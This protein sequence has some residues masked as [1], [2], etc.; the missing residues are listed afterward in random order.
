MSEVRP[1]VRP[2]VDLSAPNLRNPKHKA[3]VASSGDLISKM[4]QQPREGLLPKAV[5][6]RKSREFQ[7]VTREF[8]GSGEAGR[9]VNNFC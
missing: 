7:G 5:H 8:V 9:P 3:T 1:E 4:P 2:A 6:C